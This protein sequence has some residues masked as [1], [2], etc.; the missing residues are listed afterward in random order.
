L[1]LHYRQMLAQPA[2]LAC[3]VRS[4]INSFF[5]W[6]RTLGVPAVLDILHA[7][8][9]YIL[10]FFAISSGLRSLLV[11]SQ[12]RQTYAFPRWR[13]KTRCFRDVSWADCGSRCVLR[14]RT[15]VQFSS[16]AADSSH[17]VITWSFHPHG[18]W[19]HF[20]SRGTHIFC[21]SPLLWFTLVALLRSFH[22]FAS[23]FSAG[24]AARCSLRVLFCGPVPCV[25]RITWLL[26]LPYA[27][28]V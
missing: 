12:T 11:G 2:M 13:R 18:G 23:L 8:Y 9:C 19:L 6:W 27:G 1:Y 4:A 14:L 24:I 3:G 17:I 7:T 15:P 21:G 5:A 10:C 22:S 26:T 28:C 16:T 20:F 25:V